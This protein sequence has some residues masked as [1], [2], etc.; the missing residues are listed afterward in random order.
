MLCLECRAELLPNAKFC[1]K[2]GASVADAR[3][4]PPPPETPPGPIPTGAPSQAPGVVFQADWLPEAATKLRRIF[5]FD[6]SVYAELRADPN[7]TVLSFAVT[8]I[9]I[10]AFALGGYMWANIEVGDI[11]DFRWGGLFWESVL[12]GSLISF[13]LWGVWIF[14]TIVVLTQVYRM[15]LRLDEVFRVTGAAS[16]PLA[17]GFLMFI[18]GISFGVALVALVTWVVASI[19]A[20]QTAFEMPIQRAVVASL[21]GFAV[22]AIILPLIVGGDD[23]LGPGIMLF[24]SLKD[25]AAG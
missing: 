8:A 2:C 18:P 25:L 4:A 24:D 3:G 14:A 12:V 20:L 22:W 15:T 1:A 21:A 7:V 5:L 10:L 13:V 16:A 17:I 6:P 19:F 9:A 23:P 11:A